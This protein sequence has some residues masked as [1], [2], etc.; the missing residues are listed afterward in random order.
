MKLVDSSMYV[1]VYYV[2][3]KLHCVSDCSDMCVCV[4]DIMDDM[5]A[6]WDNWPIG[7]QNFFSTL[8]YTPYTNIKTSAQKTPKCTTAR[9][10]MQKKIGSG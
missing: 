8:F 9:Q 3:C 2:Q 5:Y 4:Y 1:H 7:T 10:K 6:M